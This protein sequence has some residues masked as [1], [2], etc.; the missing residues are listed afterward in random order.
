M[1]HEVYCF[2][3]AMDLGSGESS[4]QFTIYA[5][6][7]QR[8]ARSGTT[9]SPE[10][11]WVFYL[12]SKV[13]LVMFVYQEPLLEIIMSTVHGC[14]HYSKRSTRLPSEPIRS[15]SLV[16]L[17]SI[18]CAPPCCP[19]IIMCV[20]SEDHCLVSSARAMTFSTDVATWCTR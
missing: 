7:H 13:G 20:P 15:S 12:G 9:F 1:M 19:K 16:I 8:N 11:P 17:L 5:E 4:N 14:L 10:M 2:P 3:P 18:S 6:R